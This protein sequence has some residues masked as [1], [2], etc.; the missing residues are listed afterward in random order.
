ML[1]S[2]QLHAQV[3]EGFVGEDIDSLGPAGALSSFYPWRRLNENSVADL[4][5]SSNG[6]SYASMFYTRRGPK[7]QDM[8]PIC[9]L[10]TLEVTSRPILV[11]YSSGGKG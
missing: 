3:E 7:T 6:Q 10:T 9:L 8:L 11:S 1:G 2:W 4:W 5:E